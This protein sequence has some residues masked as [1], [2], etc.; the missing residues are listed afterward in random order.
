MVKKSF[1]SAKKNKLNPSG[2]ALRKDLH[3]RVK[4]ARGRKL[5]STLWLERQLNDP[6]VQA[7]KQDG[8]RSRAAYKLLQ[9]NQ[10][11]GFLQKDMMA[12]DLGAAPGGWSQVLLQYCGENR[13]IALD[14][15][16]MQPIEGVHIIEEDC[17]SDA[18]W[19][20]IDGAKQGRKID[21]VLSDM[22]A[23]TIGHPKTDQIRTMVLAEMAYEFAKAHLSPGGH[24]ICKIFQ[25][26]ATNQLLQA[27]RQDFHKLHHAK[28][29]ASRKD[30]VE[31]YL[32][33]LDYRGNPLKS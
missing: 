23:P 3:Q 26:G 19:H 20:L 27:L 8:Y 18:A 7:A 32:V 22:A 17:Q 30:S 10:K 11:F 9:L 5:S 13:V 14:I 28:P 1:K 12:I 24:F 15:L 4:T 33:A 2:R 16:P 21:L 6:Y 29:D 31:A 25:G